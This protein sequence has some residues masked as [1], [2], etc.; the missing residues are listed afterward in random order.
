MTGKPIEAFGRDPQGLDGEA[1]K[2]AVRAADAPETIALTQSQQA[3][4][5]GLS[6]ESREAIRT[7]ST[8]VLATQGLPWCGRCDMR[9][10]G[11]WSWC[12]HHPDNCD[13]LLLRT[14]LLQANRNGK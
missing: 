2:A 4:L 1:T 13:G 10:T 6:E 8:S 12:K 5:N 3:I 14:T 9:A 7:G 11:G